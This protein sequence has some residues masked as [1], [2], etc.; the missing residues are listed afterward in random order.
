MTARRW[1]WASLAAPCSSSPSASRRCSAAGGGVH[2][3]GASTVATGRRR[4]GRTRWMTTTTMT[5]RTTSLGRDQ[6]PTSNMMTTSATL[7][8]TLQCTQGRPS[9]LTRSLV[10]LHPLVV[11]AAALVVI[12]RKPPLPHHSWVFASTRCS[13]ILAACATYRAASDRMSSCCRRAARAVPHRSRRHPLSARLRHA[14]RARCRHPRPCRH[15][16][17]NRHP[18]PRPRSLRAPSSSG[19]ERQ[20]RGGLPPRRRCAASP[21]QGSLVAPTRPPPPPS[22]PS[23]TTAQHRIRG[24]QHRRRLA[25][26]LARPHAR[27]IPRSAPRGGVR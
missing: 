7:L 21:H 22:A 6:Q 23:S 26:R 9:S 2:G 27:I 14:D 1:R 19:S 24:V 3:R 8:W 15:H 16:R 4:V 17:A 18:V 25:R 13:W 10:M 12:S 11:V 20:A 5:T